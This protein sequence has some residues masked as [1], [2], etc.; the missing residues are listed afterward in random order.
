MPV[1]V[2]VPDWLPVTDTVPE[3]DTVGQEDAEADTLGEGDRV[4]DTVLHT[5]GEVVAEEE[6][7]P[8]TD[9]EPVRVPEMLG[10]PLELIEGL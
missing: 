1:P 9:R 6:V 7:E 10:L 2:L 8:D 3:T 5:D 4:F